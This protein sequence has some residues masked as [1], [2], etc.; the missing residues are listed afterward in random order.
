MLGTA[1]SWLISR[2][3]CLK[4]ICLFSMSRQRKTEKFLPCALSPY[5]KKCSYFQV[6]V[7]SGPALSVSGSFQEHARTRIKYVHCR[8]CT[9]QFLGN[10]PYGTLFSWFWLWFL[11]QG[12]EQK[13]IV[14]WRAPR[15]PPPSDQLFCCQHILP[16]SYFVTILQLLNSIPIFY[17]IVFSHMTL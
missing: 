7:S 6:W 12:H 5:P 15:K 4:V 1:E 2:A 9:S 16:C 14:S 10:P 3:P 8:W 17:I 11:S 13:Y